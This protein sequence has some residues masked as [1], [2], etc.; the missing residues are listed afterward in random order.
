MKLNENLNLVEILK[1]CP[2]GTILYS[3]I[4]GNVEL[5]ELQQGGGIEYPISISTIPAKTNV[6]N[7]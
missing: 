4:F 7:N 5:V 6:Y 3:P 2:M 1:G